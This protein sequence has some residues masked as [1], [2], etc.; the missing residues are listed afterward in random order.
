MT[1]LTMN[2]KQPHYDK[3]KQDV[4]DYGEVTVRGFRIR[5]TAQLLEGSNR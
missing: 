3:V 5:D 1:V 4:I 2:G